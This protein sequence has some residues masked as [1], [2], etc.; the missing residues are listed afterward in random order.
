MFQPEADDVREA[1]KTLGAIV[2][3]GPDVELIIRGPDSALVDV[4]SNICRFIVEGEVACA[5]KSQSLR[6]SRNFPATASIIEHAKAHKFL[7]RVFPCDDSLA[8]ALDL[9]FLRFRFLRRLWFRGRG[10]RLNP[11]AHRLRRS[12]DDFQAGS[13]AFV[14]AFSAPFFLVRVLVREFL[15]QHRIED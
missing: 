1:V 11:V 6:K 5:D 12:C 7:V 8:H 14:A 2:V 3:V 4:P 15:H 9:N 13:D 10:S